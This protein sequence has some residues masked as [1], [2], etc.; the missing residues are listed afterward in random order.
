MS[1]SILLRKTLRPTMSSQTVSD[2]ADFK[3][4]SIWGQSYCF[5][6]EHRTHMPGTLCKSRDVLPFPWN[7]MGS[8]SVHVVNQWLLQQISGLPSKSGKCM[9]QDLLGALTPY[10]FSPHT[11]SPFSSAPA[12]G[13]SHEQR[14]W[15]W[16]ISSPQPQPAPT[17]YPASSH[18]QGLTCP[19]VSHNLGKWGPALWWGPATCSG[20]FS[21]PSLTL[22][23]WWHPF[24]WH[25]FCFLAPAQG[26]SQ[27]LASALLVP[28]LS[29]QFILLCPAHY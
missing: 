10:L 26:P 21:K 13:D 9:C 3:P 15:A 4:G 29:P 17:W 6:F 7:S 11:W 23:F 8:L 20:T 5:L 1:V 24:L 27:F 18:C 12:S 28:S 25:V 16:T 19:T 2:R 22:P 14:R